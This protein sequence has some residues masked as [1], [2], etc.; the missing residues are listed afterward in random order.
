ME[1]RR[2]E[3]TAIHG[4]LVDVLADD[5]LSRV[6]VIGTGSDPVQD[7]KTLTGII[8]EFGGL[9]ERGREA[10]WR[11]LRLMN[12]SPDDAVRLTDA[13]D[14]EVGQCDGCGA[15]GPVRW[16]SEAGS[17][18]PVAQFCAWGCLD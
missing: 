9:S 2:E 5:R 7:F 12:E 11:L 3:M 1:S 18:E 13:I 16:M 14:D 4:L 17:D 15:R 10:C 6:E 8:R